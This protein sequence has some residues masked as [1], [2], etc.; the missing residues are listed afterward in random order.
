[1][2]GVFAKKSSL[3]VDA[4]DGNGKALP[5]AGN[6][7]EA[8]VFDFLPA[9]GGDGVL[10]FFDLERKMDPSVRFLV[11][12]LGEMGTGIRDGVEGPS[13]GDA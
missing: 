13:V 1:M 8:F 3:A 4:G 6:D 2:V 12:E 7:G 10:S 11:D 5:S 9:L